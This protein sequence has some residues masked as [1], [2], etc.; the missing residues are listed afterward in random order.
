VLKPRL[1]ALL[2]SFKEGRDYRHITSVEALSAA[3]A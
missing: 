2:D 1:E 3:A